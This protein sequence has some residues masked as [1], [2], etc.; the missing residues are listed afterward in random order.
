MKMS[1][2]W[3]LSALF[4]YEKDKLSPNL[5]FKN[6]RVVDVIKNHTHLSAGIG[7]KF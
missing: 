3:H 4:M 7:T 2:F 6:S 1:P 5:A